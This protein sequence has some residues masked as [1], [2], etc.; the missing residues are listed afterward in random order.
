MQ[1]KHPTERANAN[2][3]SGN[4]AAVPGNSGLSAGQ[5]WLVLS[6]A[7]LGWMFAGLEI[8]LFV[9]I[10][11]PAMYDLLG[12]Q[13]TE[14][15]VGTW[16]AWY[17][18][19]FLLGAAAGGWLLGWLGDRTGRTRAMAASIL[20]YSIL[21]GVSYFAGDPFTLLALRFFACLGIGGAWPNAVS[22]SVEAMPDV[23]RPLLAGLLGAAAN[24]GF[25]LLGLLCYRVAVT[26]EA[27][28][29]VLLVGAAP[30]IL[31]VFVLGW[32]PESPR[33]LAEKHGTVASLP[34]QPVREILRPPLLRRTII[35]I[36]L[37]AVPVIGTSANA[38]WLIPWSD[39]AAGR[40]Q[41]VDFPQIPAGTT[42]AAP[43]QGDPR[44]KAWTQVTRSGGAV[45]GSLLGGWVASLF[46][47]R[48]TYFLISLASFAISSYTYYFLDPLDA[49]FSLFAFLL[50]FVGVTYFGWLP[51]YLS[52]LFPT[53]VRSTGTGVTFNSGRILAAGGVLGA[54]ALMQ[55][56]GGDYARVG[57]FTGLVYVLGMVVICFA[58]DTTAKPL[59][60]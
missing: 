34:A 25:V 49:R 27:W 21:T 48:L 30:A 3:M 56:F 46:G 8:S 12:S 35:G 5:Q 50:G 22:L 32:L 58:P 17:Q 47:R 44:L 19:A 39:Q 41:V 60:D 10:S 6:A 54:G 15:D 11:R 38:N 7:F 24:V 43:R 16:F 2:P 29:W 23:S 14:A 52:E 9:L 59:E 37:G 55:V 40:E 28:R 20:C 36:C 51:L 4:P 57:T 42:P 45:F 26:P 18:C 31:G 33:W 13:A 53:R 1:R